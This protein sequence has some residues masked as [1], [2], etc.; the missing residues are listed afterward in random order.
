M[1]KIIMKVLSGTMKFFT[2]E[3]DGFNILDS[4]EVVHRKNVIVNRLLIITNI[5]ITIFLIINNKEIP[6][7]KS[8]SLLIPSIGL[9]VLI[10]YF[11]F[12]KS[13]DFE[14]QLFGM[15]IG[16]ISVS[17]IALRLNLIH[18]APYTYIFIYFAL[19]VIALYQNRNA[20]ILGD[21]MIFVIATFLHLSAYNAIDDLYSAR[22]EIII[23]I[24]FLVM[25]MFVL[26]SMVFFSEYMDKERKN[27]L[28][29]REELEGEF[30]HVLFNV[31]DTIEDFAQVSD[32]KE[33]SSEY[34]IALMAKKMGQLLDFGDKQSDEL[35]SFA[36]VIGVNNDFSMDSSEE[37][38][39]D[40]LKNYEK[41]RYKL[42][43]GSALL[44]RTRI[45]IKSEAMVRSRYES[46]FISE[47]FKKIKSEDSNIENQIVLLCETYLTLRDKQ[48]FK[49]SFPHAKA[50]KE[51]SETF[52]HFFDESLLNV[53]LE[54]HFEFELIYEKTRI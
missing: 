30:N 20:I 49:K 31:F 1:S 37:K 17:W 41:I 6:L 5:I 50:I 19:V 33:M 35:F 16:V 45:K 46:W 4:T 10:A 14:K 54:N 36:I 42:E 18:P 3:V 23:Y 7:T 48:S 2:L 26:T 21:V 27:E 53:F 38:K 40:L 52:S 47:N 44:R 39:A 43:V 22:N 51:L 15:Y 8:L 11:V 12:N 29:K 13:K 34:V 28:K 25:F 32:E 9:N 24:V